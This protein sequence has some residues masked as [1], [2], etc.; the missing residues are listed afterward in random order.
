[1]DPEVVSFSFCHIT[2]CNCECTDW[3]IDLEGF[4]GECGRGS[5][6]DRRAKCS[7]NTGTCI[8]QIFAVFFIGSN[9]KNTVVG[10][11][12]CGVTKRF[13]GL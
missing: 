8:Y 3:Y 2:F 1:M 11:S 4:F 9:S 7:C 6:S 10:Q 12:L 13:D 5:I